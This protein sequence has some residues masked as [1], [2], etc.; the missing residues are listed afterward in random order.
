MM[1]EQKKAARKGR[2]PLQLQTT[3]ETMTPISPPSNHFRLGS[4]TF[5]V[6]LLSGFEVG[7]RAVCLCA[8]GFLSMPVVATAQSL[9]KPLINIDED[10]TAFAFAPDGRIVSVAADVQEQE[11]RYAADDIWVQEAGGK[12]KEF[13][14]ANILR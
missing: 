1:E 14:K 13:F 12:R 7:L 5:L 8:I 2:R 9:D 6:S 3:S 11:I 10:V 4:V